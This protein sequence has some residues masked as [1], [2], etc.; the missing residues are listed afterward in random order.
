MAVV[1]RPGG[2]PTSHKYVVGA[3]RSVAARDMPRRQFGARRGSRKVWGSP[4]VRLVPCSKCCD[5]RAVQ[6]CVCATAS[7]LALFEYR[8]AF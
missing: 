1:N 6:T 8:L 2:S 3:R 5:V 7:D 4:V